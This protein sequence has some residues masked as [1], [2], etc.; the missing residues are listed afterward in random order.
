MLRQGGE[1]RQLTAGKRL[2]HD[3]NVTETTTKRLCT[4]PGALKRMAQVMAD[5]Q[6]MNGGR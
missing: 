4:L 2:L 3:E 6:E 5:R 1:K